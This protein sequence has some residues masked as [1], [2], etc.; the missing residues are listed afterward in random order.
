MAAPDNRIQQSETEAQRAVR[1]DEEEAEQ[2]VRRRI[3]G[4]IRDVAL[5]ATVF[6]G[7]LAFGILVIPRLPTVVGY[8]VYFVVLG[9]VGMY[10]GSLA[11]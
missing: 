7:F 2:R 5:I 4:P 9:A 1:L 6:L 3:F 10:L 8:A 11:K